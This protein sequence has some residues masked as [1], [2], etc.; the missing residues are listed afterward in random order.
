MKSPPR[1]YGSVKR[2]DYFQHYYRLVRGS[3]SCET[4]WIEP[5]RPSRTTSGT[6]AS[7]SRAAW[8]SQNFT[9]PSTSTPSARRLLG[10]VAM[11]GPNRSTEPG[12]APDALVDSARPSQMT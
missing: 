10:G 5:T 1:T 8:K 11:P 4:R 2:L 12:C 6:G 7:A 9:A 3:S